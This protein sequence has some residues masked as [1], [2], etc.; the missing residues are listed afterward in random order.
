MNCLTFGHKSSL[1]IIRGLLQLLVMLV[2]SNFDYNN[3][4]WR[5]EITWYC[6]APSRFRSLFFGLAD[7]A[8]TLP[9]QAPKSTSVSFMPD[10]RDCRT[11]GIAGWSGLP[12]YRDCRMIGTAGWSGLPDDRDCRIIEI[13]GWSGLPDYRDC[14]MIGTAGLSRFP[15]ARDCRIIEIAGWSGLP[16]YRYR[17]VGVLMT[18]REI[19]TDRLYYREFYFVLLSLFL[20]SSNFN[21]LKPIVGAVQELNMRGCASSWTASC[22]NVPLLRFCDTSG[23][24]HPSIE[25]HI[26]E[27]VHPDWLWGPSVREANHYRSYKMCGAIWLLHPYIRPHGVV[28]Y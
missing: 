27:D 19:V 8:T 4:K 24:T 13:A 2:T 9:P 17:A 12:D 18:S 3:G 26:S 6:D 21:Y 5:T 15:D 20:F 7:A 1:R 22:L 28:G 23:H 10:Y 14:R 11:I 16:D 25:R